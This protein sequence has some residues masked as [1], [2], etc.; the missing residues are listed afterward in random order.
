[1]RAFVCECLENKV[2]PFRCQGFTETNVDLVN[3]HIYMLKM[4]VSVT[5]V[6]EDKFKPTWHVKKDKK[7]HKTAEAGSPMF[8]KIYDIISRQY[9]F[10]WFY[11]ETTFWLNLFNVRRCLSV[12][13][14][15][16]YS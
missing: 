2:L 1:M 9:G 5:L 4:Y 12:R 15:S 3:W 10:M 13:T 8:P 6:R 11:N 14:V 7:Q 16:H